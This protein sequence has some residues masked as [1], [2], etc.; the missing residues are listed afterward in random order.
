MSEKYILGG[1]NKELKCE[2]GKLRFPSQP[3][4]P[5]C[6][7][8]SRGVGEEEAQRRADVR[9]SRAATAIKSGHYHKGTRKG[10]HFWNDGDPVGVKRT[11]LV[12]YLMKQ[13]VDCLEARLIASRKYR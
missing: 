3:L 13:G 2:C 1:K 10:T 12:R 11:H 9:L 8:K 5:L 4:C 7:F 6:F